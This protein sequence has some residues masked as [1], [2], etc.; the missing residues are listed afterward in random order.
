MSPAQT[1]TSV[2]MT[3]CLP[4]CSISFKR[5]DVA[6]RQR[7][8]EDRGGTDGDGWEDFVQRAAGREAERNASENKN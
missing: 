6:E 1:R 4:T 2:K 3:S 7:D 5:T 8:K